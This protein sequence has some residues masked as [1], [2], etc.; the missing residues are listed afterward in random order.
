ME[1]YLKHF[2][3]PSSLVMVLVT[4]DG[5]VRAAEVAVEEDEVV[6]KHEEQA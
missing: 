6:S 5:G 3:N 2:S 4:D 1:N